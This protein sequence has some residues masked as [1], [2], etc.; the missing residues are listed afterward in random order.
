MRRGRAAAIVN[1][2]LKERVVDKANLAQVRSSS[3]SLPR[4]LPIPSRRQI[5]SDASRSRAQYA[6]QNDAVWGRMWFHIKQIE[7]CGDVEALTR[8]SR[9]RFVTYSVDRSFAS[10]TSSSQCIAIGRNLRKQRQR[11]FENIRHKLLIGN[12]HP[13]LLVSACD[14]SGDH[15][16]DNKQPNSVLGRVVRFFKKEED[17]KEEDEEEGLRKIQEEAINY[18]KEAANNEMQH[19]QM[20]S[21]TWLGL[22]SNVVL[23]SGKAI[24]GY[25][26]P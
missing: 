10:R 26:R 6:G 25:V 21:V 12:S 8:H 13:L 19:D 2:Q 4:S 15:G 22:G 23:G 17:G 18:K 1:K 5:C 16:S 9:R 20:R 3:Q 14:Y 7:Q 24:I 11:K